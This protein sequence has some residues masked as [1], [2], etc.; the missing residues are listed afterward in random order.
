MISHISSGDNEEWCEEVTISPG[1]FGNENG[2]EPLVRG[3]CG[4]SVTPGGVYNVDRKVEGIRQSALGGMWDPVYFN[5]GIAIHGALNVPTTPASHG[6]I[7][8]PLSISPDMNGLIDYG[9]QVFVWDGVQE[10]EFYGDQ[11]PT[12]NWRDPDYST[13]TTSTTTIPE[14]TTT[15]EA[16]VTTVPTE[17]TAATT[18]TP[19]TAAT[20]TVPVE[21]TTTTVATPT[22]ADSID[23]G[24]SGSGGSSG[25]GSGDGSGDGTGGSDD[26][27]GDGDVQG[28]TADASVDE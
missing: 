16:P 9:D 4:V 20:T 25:G 13:T 28:L 2:E 10:P 23:S 15:V 11:P 27:S 21:T 8:V 22:S 7:R 12:F 24:D 26:S 14:T 17:T 6:C 3:E 18:S 5:F 1:E 19:T